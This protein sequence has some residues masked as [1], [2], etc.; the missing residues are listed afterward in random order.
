LPRNI[1]YRK[2]KRETVNEHDCRKTRER[3]KGRLK[4]IRNRKRKR[5]KG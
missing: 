3:M 2:E 1:P 4:K 5:S